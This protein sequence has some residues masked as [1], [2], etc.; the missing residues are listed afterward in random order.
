MIRADPQRIAGADGCRGGW[1]VAAG[2]ETGPIEAHVFMNTREML[3]KLLPG[4][5]L[6]VDVPIGLTDE[7]SRGAD[8]A[9]RQYLG[10]PR[11]TSV[12]SA[13][14]RPVLEADSWEEASAI[15]R[16]IEGKGMSRQA[17]GITPKVREVDHLIRE[18]DPRQEWV[19]EAHPEVSFATWAGQ[20]MQYNKKI[21][22]GRRERIDLID[23]EFGEKTV[24]GLWDSVRGQG[25]SVD[26]L[27]DALAMLWTAGRVESG[28][29][30]TLPE[31]EQ[32]DQFNLRMEIIS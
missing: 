3:N 13:P 6:C 22:A 5:I 30:Q 1:I 29:T 15:R 25:L 18:L 21:I 12:F 8:K 27:I 4:Y 14:I 17:W 23:G 10:W 24:A 11:M 26:D 31:Q 7:G 32:R 9:A 28:R 19:R 2:T 20:S 16:E